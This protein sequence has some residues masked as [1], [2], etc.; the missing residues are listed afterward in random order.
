[1]SKVEHTPGPWF[2]NEETGQVHNVSTPVCM[3]CS[4][5]ISDEEY[6]AN[7][8]LVT[9]A[10]ALLVTLKELLAFPS[11]YKEREAVVIRAL[12]LLAKIEK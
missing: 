1:M 7:C 5:V 2:Q 4:E 11:D 12:A 8:R 9:S 10:P 6:E 3:M